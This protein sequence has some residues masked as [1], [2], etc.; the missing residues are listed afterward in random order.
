MADSDFTKVER[1]LPGMPEEGTAEEAQILRQRLRLFF[2]VGLAAS[3]I[4]CVA[5][6][7]GYRRIEIGWSSL[8]A[9]RPYLFWAFPVLSLIGCLLTLRFRSVK[10]LHLLDAAIVA[11]YI[12]FI[13]VISTVY[14]PTVTRVFAYSILL[15]AHAAFVPSR[16]WLQAAV[17][18]GV[19]LAYPLGLILAHDR[20]PEVRE[21]WAIQGGT[22]AFQNFVVTSFL[23]VLL[24]AAISVVVTKTLYHF[25]SRL[26][27]A[28]ALGNYILK[29][30][31]GRGGMGKVYEA[32]HA[33]LKRPTA[34]KVLT[35]RQQDP[36][37]ALARFKEE[38]TLCCQLTHPNT[39]TI[40]D[41]GESQNRTFYYAME[42]LQGMDLQ[43][44]VERFGPLPPARCAH[45]LRQV[46]GSLAEAH[47]HGIVHRDIKPSNI[48]ITQRGEIPD[49]VKVLDFGLAREYRGSRE[50]FDGVFAGT[51]RYTAPEC[52]MGVAQLDGR[53]DIYMLGSLGYFLLTGQAPFDY[54][55]DYELMLEHL[56]LKP[57]PPSALRPDLPPEW[58]EVILT[59]LEKA[60]EDRFQKVQDLEK[61]V[62]R[63]SASETWGPEEAR[64]WWD[65]RV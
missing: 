25:R 40:F 54:G 24:L 38:V 36:K 31:L 21:L 8:A 59:C 47:A 53:V 1:I 5:D 57:K 61:A 48:F 30:E 2:G 51:P 41:F 10:A 37:E 23:D 18:I 19:T 9:Y 55:T 12:F 33:F 60:P 20:L 22:G 62:Q 43:R 65:E 4:V 11:L 34:V 29:G 32:T 3:L 15:F 42:L 35:P 64:R 49:F 26:N 6:L 52:V 27:E 56:Q 46:C 39:I 45:F 58:D 7:L 63:L 17:G 13:T 28:Q 50:S 16:V 14:S 44:M